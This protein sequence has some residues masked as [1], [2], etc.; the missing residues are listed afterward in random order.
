MHAAVPNDLTTTRCF[1]PHD[2][3]HHICALLWSRRGARKVVRISVDEVVIVNGFEGAG[4]DTCDLI[5]VFI[6]D[7]ANPA[8]KVAIDGLKNGLELVRDLFLLIMKLLQL[9]GLRRRFYRVDILLWTP[10]PPGRD[11]TFRASFDGG[12]SE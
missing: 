11:T 1:T 3:P 12:R 2:Q 5:L 8:R 10:R 9:D 7:D 6:R 4:F